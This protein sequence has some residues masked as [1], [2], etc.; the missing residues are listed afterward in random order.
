[1]ENIEI[2]P[3][4]KYSSSEW[5][6]LIKN[7]NP[8]K[9]TKT[10]Y[11]ERHNTSRS[12]FYYWNKKLFNNSHTE[13]Y[14]SDFKEVKILPLLNKASKNTSNH[15]NLIKVTYPGG[16]KLQIPSNMEAMKVAHLIITTQ[17]AL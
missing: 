7:F 4:G 3:K 2:S 5:K 9:E 1:M 15:D 14:K 16:V 11:S 12:R 17:K 10:Q 6:L 8:D 13:Q